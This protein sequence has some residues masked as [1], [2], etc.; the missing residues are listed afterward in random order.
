MTSI[1]R[2][3]K[4][5]AHRVADGWNSFVRAIDEAEFEDATLVPGSGESLNKRVRRITASL[6]D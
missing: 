6:C 2:L 3:M 5:L 4:T 1:K